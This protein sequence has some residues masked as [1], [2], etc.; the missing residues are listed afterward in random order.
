MSEYDV[1]I[2]NVFSLEA[3]NFMRKSIVDSYGNEV[4]FGINFNSFGI[5][6]LCTCYNIAFIRV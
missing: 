4:Y 2:N 5:L 6:D 3:I 1:E